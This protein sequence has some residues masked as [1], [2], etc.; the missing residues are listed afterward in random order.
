M[1]GLRGAPY[2]PMRR[3]LVKQLLAFGDLNSK[4]ILYDLG[5]GN[6]QVLIASVRDF[7]VRE[8]VGYEIAPWPFFL[9]R[10]RIKRSGLKKISLHRQNFLDADLSQATFVYAYLFP[11]I[12]DRLAVKLAG[13]LGPGTKVLVPSFP[14]DLARH[15][16][17]LLKKE[18]KIGN[19]TAYLYEKI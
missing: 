2:V 3:K 10:W 5:S 4:D 9:S 15:P 16:E 8:A 6:G 12:V 11:K 7:H 19:I 17:F 13:E 18:A 14:I 1:S